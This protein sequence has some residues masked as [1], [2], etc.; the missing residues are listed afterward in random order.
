MP[1]QVAS[2][3]QVPLKAVATSVFTIYHEQAVYSVALAAYQQQTPN[4]AKNDFFD[5]WKKKQKIRVFFTNFDTMPSR[6]PSW[7]KQSSDSP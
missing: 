1:K 3:W 2:F 4:K 5:R 7:T 6:L